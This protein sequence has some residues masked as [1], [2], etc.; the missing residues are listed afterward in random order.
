MEIGAEIK[1][2]CLLRWSRDTNEPVL[3]DGAYNLAG[4]SF[5][6]R[7]SV[8]EFLLFLNKEAL[9][10][11]PVG[12]HTVACEG[13]RIHSIVQPDGLAVLI[14]ATEGYKQRAAMAMARALMGA[15]CEAHPEAVWRGCTTDGGCKLPQ[16]EAALLD[17]QDPAKLGIMAE[18]Q[19]ETTEVLPEVLPIELPPMPS[20]FPAPGDPVRMHYVQAGMTH[21]TSGFVGRCSLA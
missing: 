16:L 10:Q 1:A 6:T 4:C 7:G 15:F 17:W 19:Q 12:T 8:R 21:F 11:M 9:K 5:F 2:A 14:T 20:P 3:L 13:H 18:V